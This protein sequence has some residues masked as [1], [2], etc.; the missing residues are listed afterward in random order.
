MDRRCFLALTAASIA[1]ARP[2]A[3]LKIAQI[4]TAHGHA[5]GKME[6]LRKLRDLFEVV[7]VAE[8][9]AARRER[10]AGRA[11][12]RGI[13]FLPEAEL[14][15]LPGLS[16]VAV[17][18]EVDGL[19]PAARRC[20][21]A[22]KAVHLD[23]PAGPSLPLFRTLLAEA[24]DR[25]LPVQLGYVFRYNPAFELCR[26]AVREGWLGDLIE[27]RGVIGKK[28]S[29]EQRAGHNPEPGGT[30]Y[31]LGG[32]LVDQLVAIAG[33]PAKVTA[34]ARRVGADGLVDN[35]LA[36]F[37]YPRLAATLRSQTVDPFGGPRREF[38]VVGTSGFVEIRPLEPAQATL[39]LDR[40]RGGFK[41]GVQ[42]LRFPSA[43]R[44]DAELT[45][46]AAALT[47]GKALPYDASHDLAVHEALLRA[48]GMPLE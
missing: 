2:G 42:S 7:G 44:Y 38:T 5:D 30:M 46:F 28:S 45:D 24:A 12:Y 22:G 23:K 10:T 20:I 8:A 13:P 43:G 37:E 17:E 9:D 41:A 27:I 25:K 31:E 21:A 16:A 15:A 11:A 6:T 48:S 34:Y 47:G 29:P 4:G 3:P 18:T 14:L 26:R 19:V 39:A 32:H 33:T 40:A 35:Q 36:V 1:P